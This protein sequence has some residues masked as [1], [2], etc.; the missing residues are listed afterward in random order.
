MCF[1]WEHKF[2]SVDKPHTLWGLQW[3]PGIKIWYYFEDVFFRE[4]KAATH[5]CMFFF[6]EL[7]LPMPLTS[8][9][10]QQQADAGVPAAY[11][12]TGTK[13]NKGKVHLGS[14]L[15]GEA[16]PRRVGRAAG[17]CF[18]HLVNLQSSGH[19][20]STVRKQREMNLGLRSLLPLF[21][22]SIYG[23]MHPTC[24]AGPPISTNLI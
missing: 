9:L 3:K 23:M 8:Q 7:A 11:L 19:T 4:T 24:R 22:V 10:W 15:Q 14:L 5:S 6:F 16:Q 21:A 17:A 13:P 1:P 12:V 20:A 18:S 2:A